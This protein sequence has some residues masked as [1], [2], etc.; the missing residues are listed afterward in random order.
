M[1]LFDTQNEFEAIKMHK[2]AKWFPRWRG[3]RFTFT[4]P[5]EC[6]SKTPFFFLFSLL[7]AL[8]YL[9]LWTSPARFCVSRSLSPLFHLS[10]WSTSTCIS[11]YKGSWLL[12]D[13][14]SL[15]KSL[16]RSCVLPGGARTL[17]F[18]NDAPCTQPVSHPI[19]SQHMCTSECKFCLTWV[20]VPK[21][22]RKFTS[23]KIKK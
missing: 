15:F 19:D 8:S 10:E 7:V 18:P 22:R 4:C 12:C 13:A 6:S 2:K 1:L 5:P 20:F 3:R 14:V 21:Y 17:R 9:L 23:K 11:L 16:F